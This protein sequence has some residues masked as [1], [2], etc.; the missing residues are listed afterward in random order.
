MRKILLFFIVNILVFIHGCALADNPTSAV[1][2]VVGVVAVT[3]HDVLNY[4]D[5][6]KYYNIA[7]TLG[8]NKNLADSIVELRQNKY[9][10]LTSEETLIIIKKLIEKGAD[11]NA[12]SRGGMHLL[13]EVLITDYFPSYKFIDFYRLSSSLQNLEIDAKD[14]N[15]FT[16]LTFV[17]S[18]REVSS[19]KYTL[20]MFKDSTLV[21]YYIHALVGRYG[22]DPNIAA[23]DG[24]SPLM[25]IL[26]Y[27]SDFCNIKFLFSNP[28]NQPDLNYIAPDGK[29]MT[30]YV[31]DGIK[32][33]WMSEDC[34]YS[35]MIVPEYA[36]S[37]TA[38]MDYVIKNIGF[39][40]GISTQ[41]RA[42]ILVYLLK[43]NRM[44]MAEY[45]LSNKIVKFTDTDDNGTSAA[46]HVAKS[47]NKELMAF[48]SKYGVKLDIH[49]LNEQI[50]AIGNFDDKSLTLKVGDIK[51]RSSGLD[52]V[53][54]N[55]LKK[56]INI[57]DITVTINGHSRTKNAIDLSSFGEVE[58]SS[59][60]TETGE[61]LTRDMLA[62]LMSE[63]EYIGFDF[64][65]K[66]HYKIDGKLYEFSQ[67]RK[68]WQ[69]VTF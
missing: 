25:Q 10:N 48:G 9:S 57:V 47:K 42:Y 7:R 50:F 52:I 29:S 64:S 49:S 61:F 68:I 27:S 11:I 41:D 51:N 38:F 22:A 32:R 55:K 56:E 1:N 8:K 40:D 6:L 4:E 19:T 14:D 54:T 45:M 16:A 20:H 24:E 2:Q 31:V 43:T 21:K 13:V 66:I 44:N 26:K 34:Y 15:G 53:L 65:I 12:P 37:S 62:N 5:N 17:T 36:N 67:A 63:G 35:D 39:N 3:V 46:S 18:N 30:N 60:V 58:A 23:P 28:N 69:K 33:G 59:S